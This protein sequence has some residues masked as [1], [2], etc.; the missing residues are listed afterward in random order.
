MMKRWVPQ[1]RRRAWACAPLAALLVVACNTQRDG[2]A[3]P[4]YA[5]AELI[6]L[7][8]PIAGTLA[9]LPVVR[10]QHVAAGAELFRL[11]TDA[12]ALARAEAQAR[13]ERARAQSANLRKGRRPTELRAIEQQLVQARAAL[14]AS[15][16][17]LARNEQLVKQGFQSASTLDTLHATR[18]RDAARVRELDAQLAT[19]RDAARPDEIAAAQADLNAAEQ[20]LAQQRWRE[21]QK[22]RGAP[23]AATVFE[24]PYRVGEWVAAGSPVVA[25]LPDV[26]GVK[27]R[28]FVPQVQLARLRVGQSVSVQCDGCPAGLQATVAY[29]SP[30]AEF[31]PPVIYSN[32]SRQKLVFMVEARPLGAAREVLKPGQPVEVRLSAAS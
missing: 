15:T 11:D 19:A 18:D 32:E 3:L 6:Y 26:G 28:F 27:L 2:A 16:A 31:T 10:G 7:S 5:E 4:G 9:A 25:L 8:S 12:E 17:L 24:L 20:V 1:A 21:D 22:R 14:A 29:V 13:V 30:Q 23:V